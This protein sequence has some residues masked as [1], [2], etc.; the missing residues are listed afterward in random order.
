MRLGWSLALSLAALWC[1]ATFLPAIGLY[2]WLP[3]VVVISVMLIAFRGGAWEGLAAAFVLGIAEAWLTGLSRGVMLLSLLPAVWLGFWLR[4]S[5]AGA[6]V[7]VS[8][9]VVALG[10]VLTDLAV[11]TLTILMGMEV[12]LL[13]LLLRVVPASALLTA[14]LALPLFAL[15]RWSEPSFQ[16]RS[17]RVIGV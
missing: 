13:P 4:Q 15:N 1:S 3:H 7:F 10:A 6:S 16:R 14:L 12:N 5:A 2:V 9:A 17:T 11:A 8:A